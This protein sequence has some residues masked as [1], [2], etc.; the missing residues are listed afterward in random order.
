[1]ELGRIEDLAR[2]ALG[3]FRDDR[4]YDDLW[5]EMMIV[6]IGLDESMPDSWVVRT[7]KFRAIDWLRL[8]DGRLTPDHRRWR[9]RPFSYDRMVEDGWDLPSTD[10]MDGISPSTML[11]LTGRTA[12]VVDLRWQGFTSR[13]IGQMFGVTESRISQIL[14]GVRK[15]SL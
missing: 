15:R 1:M 11:G 6:G 8:R 7:I 13:E 4:D 3:R 12:V 14:N 2:R 10:E 9:Y 5:Q